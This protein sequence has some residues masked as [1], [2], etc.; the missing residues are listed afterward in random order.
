LEA[1]FLEV[2]LTLITGGAR[3]GK[4]SFSQ[5]LCADAHSVAYVASAIASDD[6]MRSRIDRH[7]R[8]RPSRWLTIEE[9]LAIPEAVAQGQKQCEI[10]LLDCVTLWLSNL[11]YEWRAEDTAIVEKRVANSAAALL[12]ACQVGRVIA[13]T[14]EVGSGL[15]PESAVGR[16]FRDLQ[17]FVNQ[18]LAREADA[19][20][21]LVSGIPMR[22]K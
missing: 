16:H 15:V 20:Y 18:Q 9:P 3:S 21:L 1:Q 17:G 2:M 14:N 8:D 19:V 4:S 22:V 7:R 6:E 10:V 11:L 13:V 12:K 5:S